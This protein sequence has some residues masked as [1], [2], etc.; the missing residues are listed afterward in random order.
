[1]GRENDRS[2]IVANDL[3]ELETDEFN[4]GARNIDEVRSGGGD[5]VAENGGST[6]GDVINPMDDAAYF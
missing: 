2:V 3:G 6:G 5:D 1:M 4:F